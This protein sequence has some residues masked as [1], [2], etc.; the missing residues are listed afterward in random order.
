MARKVLKVYKLPSANT[1][2]LNKKLQD[3]ESQGEATNWELVT[4]VTETDSRFT[5]YIFQGD[6]KEPPYVD[7]KNP[8]PIRY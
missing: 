8:G 7:S 6:K 3:L 1:A 4:A 2:T 5:S